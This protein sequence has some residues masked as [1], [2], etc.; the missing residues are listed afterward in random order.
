L[1]VSSRWLIA[2]GALAL[3]ILE[4][5]SGLRAEGQKTR[6]SHR[7][8]IPETVEVALEATVPV[9]LALVPGEGFH[10]DRNGPLRI[11]LSTGQGGGLKIKKGRLRWSDAVDS[12]SLEPRFLVPIQGSRVGQESMTIEYRFWLC[13]AKICQPIRGSR[14][15]KVQVRA[16]A[17]D[18]GPG[19]AAPA[20]LG[21]P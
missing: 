7:V 2:V 4:G 3:L 10:I 8:V 6:P 15:M 14:E 9:S 1:Q 16:P 5:A 19:D 11:D 17:L 21:D 13:R 20:D 12:S 18:G